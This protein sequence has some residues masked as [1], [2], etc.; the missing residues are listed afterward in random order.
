MTTQNITVLP[1]SRTFACASSANL[2]EGVE[3]SGTK[4]L[5]VGC[6]RGGC[7]V[8]RIRVLQGTY[9]TKVMSKAHCTED[10]IAAGVVLACRVF[11]TSDLVVEPYP[12]TRSTRDTSTPSS[13]QQPQ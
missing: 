11:P 2:L 1:E 4:C 10:D 6:R 9:A 3:K 8:C 13:Q 5:P 12:T 7:G